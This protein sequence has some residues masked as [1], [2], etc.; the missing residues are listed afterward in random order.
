MLDT[1][2]GMT[3]EEGQAR[4]TSAGRLR[5]RADACTEPLI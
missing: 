2:F 1:V 5:D 4:Q 3:Y